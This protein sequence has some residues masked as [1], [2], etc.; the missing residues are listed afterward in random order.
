M[1]EGKHRREKWS[2]RGTSKDGGPHPDPTAGRGAGQ[3]GGRLRPNAE[4]ESVE[5][6]A[7]HGNTL[8]TVSSSSGISVQ[9][10]KVE[11]LAIDGDHRRSV[12]GGHGSRR[13]TRTSPDREGRG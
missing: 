9:L 6:G 8:A 10:P 12:R 11:S 1:L 7:V 3:S 2:S 4:I 13:N 5:K